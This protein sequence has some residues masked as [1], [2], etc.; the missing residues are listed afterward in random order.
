MNKYRVM[1]AGLVMRR[2]EDK[3]WD[4]AL[5]GNVTDRL[6]PCYSFS[7]RGV[8]EEERL[9]VFEGAVLAWAKSY[10]I[11]MHQPPEI[12]IFYR[13]KSECSL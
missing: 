13:E 4:M 8:S 5:V 9:K 6:F 1:Q 12:I 2:T 10:V 7:R 3:S 11:R